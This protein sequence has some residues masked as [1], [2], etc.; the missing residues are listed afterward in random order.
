MVRTIGNEIEL[1]F[2]QMLF[3]LVSMP[4][5][6]LMTLYYQFSVGVHAV[7]MTEDMFESWVESHQYTFINFYAPW[8]VW[9]QRLEPVWEALAEKVEEEDLPVSIVRVDCIANRDL[10]I[11]LRI[12]VYSNHK[13]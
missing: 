13:S 8:C 6:S 4:T 1:H 2:I 11:K 9:C 7:S 5:L 10:C 3:C 12:Q